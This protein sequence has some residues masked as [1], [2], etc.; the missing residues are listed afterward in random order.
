MH[1]VSGF[2]EGRVV[3]AVAVLGISLAPGPASAD[4]PPCGRAISTAPRGQVHS[5]IA[6]D[7]AG[8]A[9]ITWQDAR[10]ARVNILAQHVLAAGELDAA[11]PTNGRALLGDSL[12]IATAAGG[13]VT[14]VIVPDGAGG[15]IV[16][17]QDLRSAV[18]EI[19]LFAQHV[20][21]SGVVDPAWPANGTALVAIEGQQN[22]QAIASD[23]AGG[24][25]VAW[26]DTRPG[27]SV[28]DVFAQ[29]VLASGVVDPRWPANGL[30]VGAAPGLQEFPVIVE[31]GAG[32]AI[33]AWDD[34]R[35]STTSFDVYAQHVL[36]SG[37]VDPAWP[38]NGLALC[39]AD[40]GQGH[41][42]IAADG[43][44]GAVVAWTDSRIVGTAHIF[45]Q[46]VLASGAVDPAWPV[47]GTAVSS[48]AVLET[49]PLAV[50]DGAGGAIVNW[51]GFT[52]ELNMYVQH[53]LATGVVDPAW[54]AG[55]R[56]LTDA[57]RQQVHGVIAPDGA[58]GAVIAWEDGFEVVA[59]HVLA[60]GTLDPAYPEHGL[61]LCDNPSGRG[62]P[63]IVATGG[64]GAIVAWTDGRNSGTSPDI[65]A[66]QVLEAGTTD[67]PGA[68]PLEFTF[69]RPSPNPVRA[70]LTLRY[71]LPRQANVRLAI[72]DIAGR[73]VRELRSGTEPGGAHAI[74]WDLRDERGAPVG[75]GTYFA[76]LEVEQRTLAHQVTRV[77]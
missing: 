47:N 66:L 28:A 48:A 71:A 26:M 24:A 21:A 72:F 8:G 7:G 69:A 61:L 6:T 53:V 3:L 65:F 11:W 46:H 70:S 38:L 68:A 44:H 34:A 18:T 25:F 2:I 17:W 10:S 22:A 73:R 9:I 50:S 52:I 41:A 45:A 76:R 19:D 58:G 57:D 62:D 67:V 31:D 59:Q 37:V 40:G 30:A 14:P 27:V 12:A 74:D 51:Q 77:R 33:I 35:S 1:K 75:V 32:G 23:G 5:E 60:S 29:H 56:A 36:D 55:G 39:T 43:A 13:Q 16:A 4:W 64:G 20:L 63:A 49:R 42:T 15:A 54:P